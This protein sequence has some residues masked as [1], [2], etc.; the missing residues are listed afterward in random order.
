MHVDGRARLDE[1]TREH[2]V[3][4]LDRVDEL[5]ALHGQIEVDVEG[6][7]TAQRVGGASVGLGDVVG[8]AGRRARCAR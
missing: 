4:T 2:D 7:T 8:L 6:P 5:V 1:R 3:G